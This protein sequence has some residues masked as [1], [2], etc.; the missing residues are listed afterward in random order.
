M[1]LVDPPQRM[2]GGFYTDNYAF[3]LRGVPAGWDGPLVLRLFPAS[4]PAGQARREAIVQ[5]IAADH[6]P[7]PRVILQETTPFEERQWF[8]MERLPG[9]PVLGGLE[10]GEIL[11][12]LPAYSL[13][14]LPHLMVAATQLRCS[15]SM[16]HHS[17]TQ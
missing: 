2:G 11:R 13:V 9:R 3:R 1:E 5:N 8:I 12:T 15:A 17:S 16:P 7:A 14:R 10:I 6:V 4:A